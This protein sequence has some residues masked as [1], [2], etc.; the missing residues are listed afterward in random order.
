[1]VIGAENAEGT[2]DAEGVVVRVGIRGVEGEEGVDVEDE[3]GVLAIVAGSKEFSFL[4][5]DTIK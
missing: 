4:C 2:E 1:V 5:S 3:E